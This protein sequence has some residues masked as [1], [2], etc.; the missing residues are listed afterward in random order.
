MPAASRCSSSGS[1]MSAVGLVLLG[2]ALRFRATISKPEEGSFCSESQVA[3]RDSCYEFVPLGRTFYGA[4]SWCEEQGG[5]LV[6]IHDENTQ[7]FLQKHLSQDREWWIGLIGNSAQN[8]TTK[9]RCC[10]SC[11]SWEAYG[12][13]SHHCFLPRASW[14]KLIYPNLKVRIP[15][16]LVVLWI[17]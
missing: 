10:E 1:R 12:C 2:L 17:K 11:I 5:H 3:F 4:Q 8:G 14:N 9:G 15:S 16:S 7:Q 13:D 6:F